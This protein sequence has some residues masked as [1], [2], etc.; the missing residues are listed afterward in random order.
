ME[1]I[2]Q[3]VQ[4]EGGEN[5]H[6]PRRYKNFGV[7][8]YP[9]E[10]SGHKKFLAY[11]QS[12]PRFKV[13][14]IFHQPDKET[15]KEHCHCLIVVR[16]QMTTGQFLKFFDC[17]IKYVEGIQDRD[18]YLTYMIHATPHAIEEGKKP[19]SI[20]DLQGDEDLWRNLRQNKNFVQ[21]SEVMQYYQKGDTM[22]TLLDKMQRDCLPNDFARYF[23]FIRANSFFFM[24]ILNQEINKKHREG[25]NPNV[26][27][28]SKATV[29]DLIEKDGLV[30]IK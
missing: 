23:D 15:G 1:T 29:D 14:F 19:Y 25:Q 12:Q 26:I 5:L 24:S 17:W 21:F 16:N 6:K 8:L 13:A 4:E 20:N 22:L 18:S 9:D 3:E 28:E 7:I 30:P 11:V 10:D 2:L 27:I